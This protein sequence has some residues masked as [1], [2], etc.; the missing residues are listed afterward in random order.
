MQRDS[1]DFANEPVGSLFGKMLFPTLVGMVSIVVLN[2]TDGAFVGHGVGGDGLAA[3]NI[4]APIYSIMSGLGLM[5]GAGCSVVASIHMSRGNQKAADINITQALIACLLVGVLVAALILCNL[6]ATCRFFGSNDTLLP[7]AVSY[8]K[9]IA[10]FLPLNILSLAGEFVVRLDG[11]PRYAMFCTLVT[12]LLNIF[13]DW[14]LIFPLGCG[15]EGAAIATAVS[16]SLAGIMLMVYILFFSK[17][18]HLRRL[19][20]TWKSLR[21]SLRNIGYQMRM[22]FSAFLGELA[23][24][25]IVVVGNYVFIRYLGEAGVAAYSV[26]CYCL[27]IGLMLGNAISQSSQPIISFAYGVGNRPRLKRARNVSVMTGLLAG[28]LG[29]SFLFFGSPFITSVFL[30]RAEPG[31]SL[32]TYGL[33]RIAFCFLFLVFNLALIGYYQ[34]IERSREAIAFTL[35]RGFIFVIPCFILLPKV[36]DTDGLWLAMPFSEALTML[37]MLVYSAL[38]SRVSRGSEVSG[39]FNV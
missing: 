37:V 14:L 22:G 1:I 15:L 6:E 18:I 9:W 39:T 13:L 28:L 3:V 32:C 36:L 34:S 30:D 12:A 20:H 7:L 4:A 16:M 31:F 11:S 29:A 19:K 17:T 26:A 25:C 38:R 2:I 35:L 27:P 10:L 21:L 23:V 5:F 8:L 33:P 24:S